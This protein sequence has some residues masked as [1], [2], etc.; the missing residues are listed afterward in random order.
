MKPPNAPQFSHNSRPCYIS[1]IHITRGIIIRYMDA[2]AEFIT[3]P[4]DNSLIRE[5]GPREIPF[6]D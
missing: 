1:G 5:Y 3:I 2:D 4:Y 6:S